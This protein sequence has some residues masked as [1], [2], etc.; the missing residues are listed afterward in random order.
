MKVIYNRFIPFGTYHGLNLFGIVF[1][2]R[3]WGRME[4]HELNHEFIHTCQQWE[5]TYV[6]FYLW[7]VVEFLVRLVQYGFRA[8]KAYYNI[9]FER[10][11]YANER[12]M[13]Y[14]HERRLMAWT[15]YLRH[16]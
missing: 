11:A 15:R 6:L 5:M 13:D 12:N 10:E 4:P 9:S 2:Q 3:R 16:S 8:E 1:V 7:Y 14:L